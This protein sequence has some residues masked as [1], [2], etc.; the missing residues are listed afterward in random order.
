MRF[1]AGYAQ[2]AITPDLTRPVYLAGFGRNRRA[3]R[4]QVVLYARMGALA[5]AGTQRQVEAL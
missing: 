1:Q 3:K 5:G 2:A 4:L